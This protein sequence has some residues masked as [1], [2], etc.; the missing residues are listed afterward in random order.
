MYL[1][2]GSGMAKDYQVGLQMSETVQ[3]NTKRSRFMINHEKSIWL[4]R[5]EGELSGFIIDLKEGAFRVPNRRVGNL[6]FLLDK[7][8]C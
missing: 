1:D 7:V 3:E 5:Q 2:D 8:Q 4:P 6:K